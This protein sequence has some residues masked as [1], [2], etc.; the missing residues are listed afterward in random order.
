MIKRP[1]SRTITD[2]ISLPKNNEL[3]SLKYSF[4]K[5]KF[6]FSDEEEEIEKSAEPFRDPD[7]FQEFTFPTIV[8]AKRAVSDYL[9]MPLARLNKEELEAVD[10]IVR[11]TLNK[12]E[13]IE[14]VQ[15]FFKAR[16]ERKHGK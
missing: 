5:L 15:T 4:D 12:M 7:P 8:A 6:T 14:K 13:V 1:F 11:S 9:G 16:R 3:Y 2:F 10:S